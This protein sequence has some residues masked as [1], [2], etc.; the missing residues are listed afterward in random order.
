MSTSH[1][2]APDH[3]QRKSRAALQQALLALIARKPYAEITIEDVTEHADVARATFYA[4]YRD[5][6]T[7]LHEACRDLVNELTGRVDTAAAQSTVYSGGGGVL[8]VF[9][10]ASDHTDLYRLVVSGEGGATARAELVEAFEDIADMV[11]SRQSDASNRTPRVPV[12]VITTAF[13]GAL[14]LTLERWLREDA[15]QQSTQIALQFL[16]TQVRGLEWSLGYEPGE[17]YFEGSSTEQP[18]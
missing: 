15:R 6:S 17:T 14:V 18:G 9:Q 4:H 11:F 3:R 5:K 12:S 1:P 2:R 7:L 10:H 8:A 16:H 13:V